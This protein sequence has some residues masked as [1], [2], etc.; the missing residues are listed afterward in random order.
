MPKVS[1]SPWW[2]SAT[3]PTELTLG[4]IERHYNACVRG[5]LPERPSMFRVSE[6][7]GKR[8]EVAAAAAGQSISEWLSLHWHECV[9]V[10]A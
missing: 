6:G 3:T 9:G 7:E 4:D 1:D 5:D 10:W 2:I 8:I